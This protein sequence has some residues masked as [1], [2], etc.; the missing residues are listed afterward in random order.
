MKCERKGS[1]QEYP[2]NFA[3]LRLAEKTLA[4]A[5]QQKMMEQPRYGEGGQHKD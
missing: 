2:K 4:K 1:A 5:Q 3:L